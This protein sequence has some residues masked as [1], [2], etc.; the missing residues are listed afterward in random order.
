MALVLLTMRLAILLAIVANATRL[1]AQRFPGFPRT[2]LAVDV[3]VASIVHGADSVRV[4]YTVCN[5]RVSE[6]RRV[7]LTIQAPAPARSV[8]TPLPRTS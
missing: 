4:T 2:H 1:A 3:R 5:R 8:T 7:D 6:E